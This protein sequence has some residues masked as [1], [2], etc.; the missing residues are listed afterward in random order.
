MLCVFFPKV[1]LTDI[2]H[3]YTNICFFRRVTFACA[4]FGKQ[5]S[6]CLLDKQ[7]RE[8]FMYRRIRM[9]LTRTSLPAHGLLLHSLLSDPSGR[10]CYH[11]E[12]RL[13][14]HSTHESAADLKN[15]SGDLTE[16]HFECAQSADTQKRSEIQR[17]SNI[18]PGS[19]Q[20]KR[21]ETSLSDQKPKP[22]TT[23]SSEF[24]STKQGS[25]SGLFWRDWGWAGDLWWIIRGSKSASTDHCR[26]LRK[27]IDQDHQL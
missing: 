11:T 15:W 5:H 19:K 10:T 9:R 12:W 14:F 24:Q 16:R 21:E 27:H 7:S 13:D 1:C 6:H 18:G 17:F 20:C 4:R 3:M 23:G 26:K 8:R 25:F 22:A 2:L